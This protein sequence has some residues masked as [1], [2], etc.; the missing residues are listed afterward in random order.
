MRAAPPL[1]KEPVYCARLLPHAARDSGMPTLTDPSVELPDFVAP[2]VIEVAASVQFNELPGLDVARLGT[3]WAQRRAE[4]PK[5]EYQPRLAPQTETFGGPQ[6]TRIGFSIETSPGTPRFWFLNE[7]GTRLLQL[8]PDRLVVNWRKLD[9]DEPY[10]H[11]PSL[12]EALEREFARF[13]QFLGTERLPTPEPTQAEL[14]YVNH[15]P[16]GQPGAA[17]EPLENVMTLWGGGGGSGLLPPAEEIHVLSR[18]LMRINEEPVGRLHVQ[19]DARYLAKDNSP[20]YVLQLVGRGAPRGEGF[21]GVLAMLDLAH[22]WIVQGFT[23]ITTPEM[24]RTWRRIR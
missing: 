5:V 17:H 9:T 8:Q 4:Y 21:A 2:P 3:Y 15:I 19:L 24:H 23:A 6:A 14:T 1:G 12:R 22:V 20:V 7:N 16:A 11:Y 18:Y 13:A 10:P